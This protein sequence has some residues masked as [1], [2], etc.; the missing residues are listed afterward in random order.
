MMATLIME[1]QLVWLAIILVK[2]VLL[3]PHTA[4]HARLVTKEYLLDLSV[5]VL[6]G[7]MNLE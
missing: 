1:V 4:L 7:G 5:H 3:R 2:H 6:P